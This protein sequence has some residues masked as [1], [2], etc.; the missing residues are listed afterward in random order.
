MAK[1]PATKIA[2]HTAI[3]HPTILHPTILHTTILHT[4]ILHTTMRGIA[5]SHRSEYHSPIIPKNKAPA[6]PMAFWKPL[7]EQL[8]SGKQARSGAALADHYDRL[9]YLQQHH[10]W[11]DVTLCKTGDN[12]QS[13]ILALDPDQKELLIDELYPVESN[14]Q[15]QSGDRLEISSRS[16]RAPISFFTRILA[17]ENRQGEI[18]YRL[19]LPEDI[20]IQHSRGAFRV[21]VENEVG[22]DIDIQISG[23]AIPAVRIINLSTDG[24]KLWLPIDAESSLSASPRIEDVVIRLPNGL[25]IDCEIEL[26][27]RYVIKTPHPHIV[28]GAKLVIHNAQQRVKLQQFLAAVQ[29]KQRRKQFREN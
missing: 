27:N 24:I 5:E 11:I 15:L 6:R 16:K 20:G 22:L 12:F 19:E 29:R 14:R 9:H 7:F 1:V 10:E 3:L 4:T 18:A 23:A 25:Y 17:S 2:R 13:L 26:R 28:A 21:Y 8:F